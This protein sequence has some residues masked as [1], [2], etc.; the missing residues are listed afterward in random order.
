MLGTAA[1]DVK[2]E[3]D[4]ARSHLRH[5]FRDVNTEVRNGPFQAP[6]AG[7]NFHPQTSRSIHLKESEK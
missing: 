4:I 2:P 7:A 1:R 5:C 6:S 3:S